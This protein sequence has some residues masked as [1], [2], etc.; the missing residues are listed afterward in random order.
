MNF[1]IG[2]SWFM[3]DRTHAMYGH[4]VHHDVSDGDRGHALFLFTM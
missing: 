1:H 4:V 2:Q 3:L